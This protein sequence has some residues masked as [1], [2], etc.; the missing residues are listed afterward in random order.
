MTQKEILDLLHTVF[1]ILE[2]D[3]QIEELEKKMK[4]QDESWQSDKRT[5]KDP[6]D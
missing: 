5:P 3:L 2:L 1:E 4:K 6:G